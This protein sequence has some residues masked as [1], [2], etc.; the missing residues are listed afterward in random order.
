MWSLCFLLKLHIFG[1]YQYCYCYWIQSLL[2]CV[3]CMYVVVSTC[4]PSPPH[5]FIE[6]VMTVP[7]LPMARDQSTIWV[8]MMKTMPSLMPSAVP[9][10][11]PSTKLSSGC[12][13]SIPSIVPS[14]SPS[15][16][17]PS[18]PDRTTNVAPSAVS[19]DL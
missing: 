9:S 6:L 10:A 7:I 13:S 18:S 16:P 11:E 19:Y 14:G 2:I 4:T 8:M 1:G 15:T 3:A 12:P 5:T 17:P